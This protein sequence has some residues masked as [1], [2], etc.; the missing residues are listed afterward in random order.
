M[1]NFVGNPLITRKIILEM[2]F[3]TK[4]YSELCIYVGNYVGIY[5]IF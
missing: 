3:L 1:R 4:L 5:E 2:V